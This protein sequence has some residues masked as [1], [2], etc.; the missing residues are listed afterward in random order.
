MAEAAMQGANCS[1]G[2]IWGFIILWKVHFYMQLRG[3]RFRTRNLPITRRSTSRATAF[4][5]CW[6]CLFT[7]LNLPELSFHLH[8]FLPQVEIIPFLAFVALPR[9]QF[10]LS[11]FI[12]VVRHKTLSVSPP[13]P[14]FSPPHHFSPHL[15]HPRCLSGTL[16]PC[17]ARAPHRFETNLRWN[18]HQ[19]TQLLIREETSNYLLLHPGI[20]A[21]KAA[22][23]S[24][25]MNNGGGNREA[26]LCK[27]P[28]TL[29]SS[30]L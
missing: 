11:C 17:P 2:A 15:Y 7:H 14:V 30:V 18:K 5:I 9:F 24:L 19:T 10:N 23:I 29:I 16:H 12:A 28:H 26:C 27:F 1:S 21:Q 22:L 3:A 8:H 25:I 6:W 20:R 13:A 4:L